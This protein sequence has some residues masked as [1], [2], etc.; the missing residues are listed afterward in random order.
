[1]LVM[2]DMLDKWISYA[3][4]LCYASMLDNRG[5]SGGEFLWGSLLE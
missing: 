3:A 5:A 2:L 4:M 1:M